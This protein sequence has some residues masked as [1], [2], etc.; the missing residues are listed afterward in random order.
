M[1]AAIPL[2]ILAIGLGAAGCTSA[3]PGDPTLA[4]G[5]CLAE[6]NGPDS[7]RTS[8]VDCTEEH[9]FDVLGLVTWP[10]MAS[11]IESASAEEVFDDIT[12][13][14][15]SVT[16][17]RYWGWAIDECVGV[18]R[19]VIGLDVTVEGKSAD[20]L[21][22]IPADRWDMDVSLAAR[23]DFIAGDHTSLCSVTWRDAE[24]QETAIALPTGV[25]VR[26]LLSPSFPP[27]LRNCH[28]RDPDANPSYTP[29]DCLE[30][31]H[32]QYLVIFDGAVALGADWVESKDPDGGFD[33]YA[34]L[35]EYCTVL[36]EAVY[37]GVL[38][39]PDWIVWSDDWGTLGWESYDGTADPDKQYPV[40]C[41]IL[42]VDDTE[43][44]GDVLSG[45]AAAV[46]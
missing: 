22:L 38:D 46:S 2:L 32:G 33:D 26:D 15:P 3:G 21:D 12:G 44:S 28:D 35:D 42:G 18:M 45:E 16:G 5:A 19:E 11:A 41:G 13:E 1:K 43:I 37:P 8:L 27:E 24:N 4:A 17:D 30:A 14:A 36:L 29:A 39:S 31:H 25:T 34:P 9:S 20:E 23:E 10:D 7:D 40:Y 6:Y